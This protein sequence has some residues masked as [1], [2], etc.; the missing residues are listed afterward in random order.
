ME[1]SMH[2][3]SKYFEQTGIIAH[4]KRIGIVSQFA[5]LANIF[6]H[7]VFCWREMHPQYFVTSY[8]DSSISGVLNHCRVLVKKASFTGTS[9][10]S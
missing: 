3:Q 2:K 1:L 10:G 8:S 9:V 4:K 7:R 6:I 5:S